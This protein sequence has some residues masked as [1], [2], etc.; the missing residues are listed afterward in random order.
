MTTPTITTRALVFAFLLLSARAKRVAIIGGGISGTFAAKYLTD[1][2]TNCSLESIT[3]L[4]PLPIGQATSVTSKPETDWQGS[5]V[6]SL[7]LQDGSIV[8]LGASVA[9][10]GF[11]L[12]MDM[13]HADDSVVIGQAHNAGLTR[14]N[15]T[16]RDGIGIYNGNG[17]WALL[18]SNTPSFLSKLKLLWRYNVD[19]FIM[20]RAAD[21]AER[22]LQRIQK[23]LN[24]TYPTTFF[25]APDE[26]WNAAGLLKP[27]HLSF[28]EFLDAL[29][30]PH[31]LPWWRRLL[32][33]QGSLRAE[34]LTAINLCNY[35]Q[36]NSQVNGKIRVC[37]MG[38][39]LSLLLLCEWHSRFSLSFSP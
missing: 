21:T 7:E 8:E 31:E 27:A 36:A 15:D 23:W 16:T 35:N 12:V 10:H 4:D 37:W 32:P 3:I 29:G 9:F 14:V 22:G 25:E 2:D 39:R 13:I 38:M 11:R 33:Y 24:S 6:A 28:D 19:L 34:L 20:S 26:M 18:T 30:L 5:R 17:A 1:Y